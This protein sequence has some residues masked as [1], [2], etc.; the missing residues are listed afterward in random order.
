MTRVFNADVNELT[1]VID[2]LDDAIQV[3]NPGF[4]QTKK[5]ELALEESF[6]N[7]VSY[8]YPNGGGKVEI[9]IDIDEAKK[10]VS[11]TLIDEGIP[12]DPLSEKDP[13]VTL[14]AEKRKVGGLG[15]FLV[16]KNTDEQHY[17]YRDSKNIM[18]FKTTLTSE[19]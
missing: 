5:L 8:A 7:I 19:A 10:V 11:V 2:Y 12:F 1:G 6:V 9:D 14:P 16:K 3:L 15:I 17:E 4:R 13:D 18:N